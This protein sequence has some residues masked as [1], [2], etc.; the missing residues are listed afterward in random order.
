MPKPP[1]IAVLVSLNGA[2]TN[3]SLGWTF[4]L[5]FGTLRISPYDASRS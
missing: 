3:P 4:D 1:R 2:H 5:S